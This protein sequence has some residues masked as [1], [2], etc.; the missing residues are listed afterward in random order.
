MLPAVL[1]KGAVVIKTDV[2]KGS[3]PA[4]AVGEIKVRRSPFAQFLFAVRT[5]SLFIFH[6]CSHVKT[7]RI[8]DGSPS[9]S[10]YLCIQPSYFLEF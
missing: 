5:D 10:I 6:N 9:N 7:P 1:V 2:Q 4:Q 3:A 8:T